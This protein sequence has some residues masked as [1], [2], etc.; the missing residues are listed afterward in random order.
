V[1]RLKS[2]VNNGAGDAQRGKSF[3]GEELEVIKY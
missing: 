3:F 2:T 1:K